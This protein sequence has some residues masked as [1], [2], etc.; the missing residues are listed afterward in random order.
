MSQ[1]IDL[2]KKEEAVVMVPVPAPEPIPVAEP[3]LEAEPA[4]MPADTG[5]LWAAHMTPLPRRDRTLYFAGVLAVS[6]V[7][8]AWF[9]QDLLFTLVL[10]LAALVL[11]LNT[12]RPH[13]K[14]EVGV[15]AT[16]ISI[17]GQ[18]HYYGSIRSFWIDYE[19]RLNMKELSIELRKGYTPRI[20]I[21]L[22][23]TDPVQIRQAM[24]P[25]VAEKE[26]EQ[27]LLDHVVRLLEI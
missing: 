21:P 2:R 11:V 6:A 22:E 17:D 24:I 19:P 16:G 5:I 1:T 9:A 27:T 26:H 10:A 25:Y 20:R 4:A 7:L 14:S 12:T 3:E 13:R 23:D 8:V 15:H 18:H